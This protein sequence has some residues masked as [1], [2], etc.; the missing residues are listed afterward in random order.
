MPSFPHLSLPTKVNGKFR[1]PQGGSRIQNTQ[2][3]QNL[4]NR[5]GHGEYLSSSM[6]QLTA[7]WSSEKERRS[8]EQLPALPEAYPIFLQVDPNIF[9]P[10]Q[11]KTSFGLEVIAEEDNGFIIGSSIDIN[12]PTLAEKIDKFVN[13]SGKFKNKA[14]QLW[15]IVTG[16][17]WRITE[18]LSGELQAKWEEIQDNE[19]YIVDVGIACSIPIPNAPVKM[20]EETIEHHNERLER[21]KNRKE[22]LQ[23]ERDEIALSRQDEFEKFIKNY[24]GELL[25]SFV[26]AEDSF[27]CRIEIKGIGLKDLVLTYPYV[28]EV[29]EAEEI[30]DIQETTSLHG[31]DF[32]PELLAPSNKDPKVC[33]IDSGIQESHRLLN[34]A[35]HLAASKSFISD[36]STADLV[37]NG[38]HGTRVSGV[39][40][41]GISIPRNGTYQLSCWIQNA[42][43][44]DNN[45]KMP[46][47]LYPPSVMREIVEYYNNNFGTRIFN[48]S[49]NSSIACRRLHMSTWAY[50]IDKLMS[51]RDIIFIVT[52][53]NI[54]SSSYILSIPGIKQ[55]LERGSLY[56]DYL[57]ESSSRIANPAQSCFALTVGSVCIS[58]YN[59]TDRKSFGCKDSISSF[60]RIGP[61]IWGMVKPDIVSYGGDFIYQNAGFVSIAEHE[62]TSP[63]LVRATTGGGPAISRDK[64]GCSFAAPLVT[65]IIASL[66][67]LLP[68]E[69]T[70]LYRALVANSSSWPETPIG[71]T[72]TDRMLKFYGFGIANL[73]K[74]ID[75]SAHRITMI[76]SGSISAKNADVYTIKVPDEIR[77]PGNDNDILIEVTLSFKARPRR[78]RRESKS[79][80][81][82][83]LSWQSSKLGES[84][85]QFTKRVLGD[86]TST[87]TTGTGQETIK[88]VIGNRV[89]TGINGIR[90]N[91]SSLQKDWTTIKVYA[92]PENFSIAVIGHQGWDK[93]PSSCVDYSL[94]VSFEDLSRELPVYELIRIENQIETELNIQTEIVL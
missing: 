63:E 67:K 12:L 77:R 5:S 37:T 43:I 3:Q 79:Y 31:L 85:S 78:T 66:Q 64:V 76:S 16:N 27:S 58:E 53:G 29:I 55:H 19:K 52:V 1:S 83:W 38:G 56:P 44:L 34:P 46:E 62:E 14:A 39:V 68:T 36:S 65:Q 60:S 32:Y 49:V 75:N 26:E 84:A 24:D 10:D 93:D 82:T 54:F 70:L 71:D 18:I 51:E 23:R 8:T 91:N 61:G 11:I 17:Q 90:L 92:L 48:L 7:E 40:L 88:W 73:E 4:N 89:N 72:A 9:Q 15:Q 74:T 22:A 57:L 28:F 25:D 42:R 87:D 50:E 30:Y 69:S 21:W 47:T 59:T 35:I 41:F 6:H 94:V 86:E 45:C 81:S 13:M 20:T 80:L 2:T 33:I